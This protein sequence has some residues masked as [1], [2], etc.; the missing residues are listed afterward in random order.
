MTE[1]QTQNNL[2][3][4]E[5][6][7]ADDSVELTYTS[8]EAATV[9]RVD[10]RIYRGAELD[11]E[12]VPFVVVDE[13]RFPLVTFRGK[14]FIDGDGDFFEFTLSEPITAGDKV[15]VEVTNRDTEF[16][17]DFSVDVSLDYEG[18][19]ERSLTSFIGRWF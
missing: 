3:F 11:L 12:V 18:G 14:E 6:V 19:V 8:E 5:T 10:V 13:Q 17:Y 2:R 16:A 7:P 1:L 9:E 15:G 4:A